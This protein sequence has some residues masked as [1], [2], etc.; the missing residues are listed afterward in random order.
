M[1]AVFEY[2]S[3]H[4][5]KWCLQN[6][7]HEKGYTFNFYLNEYYSGWRNTIQHLLKPKRAK[8][9]KQSHILI[10]MLLL[11]MLEWLLKFGVYQSKKGP[12]SKEWRC[13]G[14]ICSCR[15]GW[16]LFFCQWAA[17]KGPAA[18]TSVSS[19]PEQSILSAAQHKVAKKMDSSPS[20]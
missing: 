13:R 18:F 7:I 20:S 1:V 16:G 12:D 10:R 9:N 15:F 4:I 8:N 17:A 6:G 5:A 19:A 2:F 11:K 3:R 14:T